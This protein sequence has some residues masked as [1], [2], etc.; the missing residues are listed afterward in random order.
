MNIQI[1]GCSGGVGGS[2]G[3]TCIRL[4]EHI[5]IDAG[6]GLG[7]LPL[8]EM[9]KIKHVVLT[10][11]HMDHI[12][13]LPAFISNLFGH[14]DGSL[15]VYALP[16]TIEVLRTH[17]FNWQVWPDFEKLPSDNNPIME[18]VSIEPWNPFSIGDIQFTPFSVEHTVPTVGYSVQNQDTHFVFAADTKCNDVLLDQLNRLPP[19]DIFMAECAFPDHATEMAEISGHLTPATLKKTV[20]A[21]AVQP[22]HIWVT[23][24]K[25]AYEEELR[26]TFAQDPECQHWHVLS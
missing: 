9:R 21:L 22:Q 12:C 26:Y 10:H 5:L 19:I 16:K 14:L 25:P 18:F 3:S 1:L 24:L 13:F 23:H 11:G 20:A 15:K 7:E 8:A 2:S 6:S 4:N 17:I